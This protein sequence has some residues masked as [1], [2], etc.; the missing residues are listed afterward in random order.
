MGEDQYNRDKKSY[1]DGKYSAFIQKEQNDP[2][3][4]MNKQQGDIFL[5]YQK[6]ELS[7]QEA[8]DKIL[9]RALKSRRWLLKHDDDNDDDDD[10][11]GAEGQKESEDEE[12]FYTS[13]VWS[14]EDR[15]L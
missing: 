9:C 6:G 13:D 5:Q 12:F 3:I 8:T 2:R 4:K 7:R 15:E 11:Q 14:P 1:S 10:G